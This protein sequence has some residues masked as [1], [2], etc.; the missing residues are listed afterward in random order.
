MKVT[1]DFWTD[2]ATGDDVHEWRVEIGGEVFVTR[3]HSSPF[4]SLRGR[5]TPLEELEHR[6]QRE[7]MRAIQKQ[8]F[9]DR[10]L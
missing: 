9:K 6:A 5:P 7:L 4:D 1:R 8:L 2:R 10:T 3:A